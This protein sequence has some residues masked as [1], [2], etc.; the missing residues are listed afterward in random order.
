WGNIAAGLELI[1]R[2]DSGDCHAMTFPLLTNASGAKFGKTESGNVW[3]DPERTSPYR[4]YQF[5]INTDDRD[6]VRNLRYF[7]MLSRPEIEAIEN[8]MGE[9]TPDRSAPGELAR[10]ANS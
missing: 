7:T 2:T 8:N 4:F 6:A 5:W 10:N 1:R 9:R 3:L